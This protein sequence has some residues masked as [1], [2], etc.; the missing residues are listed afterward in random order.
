MAAHSTK[1]CVQIKEPGKGYFS[2]VH[3]GF[4]MKCSVSTKVAL[5][6]T[7]GQHGYASIG[8]PTFGLAWQRPP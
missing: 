2:L 4:G 8:A 3:T 7:W 1:V 6:E 5:K